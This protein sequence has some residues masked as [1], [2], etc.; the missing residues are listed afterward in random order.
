MPTQDGM[1]AGTDTDQRNC[2]IQRVYSRCD[3]GP[4]N[5]T[6]LC[7][8]TAQAF[9]KNYLCV[10][11]VIYDSYNARASPELSK[12]VLLKLLHL[13]QTFKNLVMLRIPNRRSGMRPGSA[14][15]TSS[16]SCR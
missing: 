2:R 3:S 11:N 8:E 6:V 9:F 13:F 15:L 5:C 4:T 10:T 1:R 12:G 14:F 16:K 7:R